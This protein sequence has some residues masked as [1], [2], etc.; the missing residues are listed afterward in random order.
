MK[1]DEKK[2][3]QEKYLPQRVLQELHVIGGKRRPLEYADIVKLASS[4]QGYFD[5][6]GNLKTE[7]GLELSHKSALVVT[8]KTKDSHKGKS[9]A[10]RLF[11]LEKFLRDHV[12]ALEKN[13]DLN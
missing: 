3:I 12:S 7:K 13:I 5:Q 9:V 11:H 8:T 10:G 1:V 6:D 4:R 2:K